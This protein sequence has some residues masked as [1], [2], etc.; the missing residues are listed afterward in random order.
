[1]S[2]CTGRASDRKG[3]AR[4]WTGV[5]RWPKVEGVESG[6]QR[7][8]ECAQDICRLTPH[9]SPLL[10]SVVIKGPGHADTTD[11]PEVSN[12]ELSTS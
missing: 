7:H 6:C 3:H 10:D 4:F 9:A 2:D 12:G 1:M 8:P 11:K 5:L